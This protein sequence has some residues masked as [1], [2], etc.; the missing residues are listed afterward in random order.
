MGRAH[1]HR[2]P[3]SHVPKAMAGAP[4]HALYNSFAIIFISVSSMQCQSFADH[5]PKPMAGAPKCALQPKGSH[6]AEISKMVRKSNFNLKNILFGGTGH[7]S[8]SS[9]TP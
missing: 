3:K 2:P 4:K 9:S 6:V 5:I 7:A 1:L 8:T